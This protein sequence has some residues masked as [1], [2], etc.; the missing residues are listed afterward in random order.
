MK[1]SQKPE[2]F[3]LLQSAYDLSKKVYMRTQIIKG[4]YRMKSQV[5]CSALSIAANLAELC[6]YD[7]EKE[8]IHKLIICAGEA[9]ETEI[10]LDFFKDVGLISKEDHKELIN[11]LKPIR[12]GIF[13]LKKKIWENIGERRKH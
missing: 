4:H 1:L 12:M 13:N 7:H 6:A 10:R 9:N 3:K 2:N 11:Q 8:I 5:Q